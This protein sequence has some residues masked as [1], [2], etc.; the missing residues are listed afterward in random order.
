MTILDEIIAYKR[1]FVAEQKAIKQVREFENEANF[2]L[3]VI[4]LKQSLLN[5]AK[6][7]IIAEFKRKSPSKGIIN[8]AVTVEQVTMG[9]SAAGASALSVL[10][11]ENYFGGTNADV[12]AARKV[13][14]CPILRKEFIVDEYQI[15]EA[16][17]LGADAILLIAACLSK[18]EINQLARFAKSF[19]LEVLLELHG[20]DEF[21]KISPEVE[22][23]GINNRNLK[24]FV[25][26]IEQSKK[27]ASK[28][29]DSFIKVAE[30]GIDSVDVIK[31]FKNHGFKGFLMGEHFMKT[32]DPGKACTEF[33]NRLKG[34]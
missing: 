10:T 30:S 9:Y 26:D 12:L 34:V 16:K 32:A 3:P 20:E 25:V 22:L 11:D 31:D 19:G 2:G 23:V 33:I 5:T 21:D 8:S 13:N 4:S 28:I 24:T 18:Q 14:T 17:S 15:V 6:S 29:P 1:V 27:F 7:G